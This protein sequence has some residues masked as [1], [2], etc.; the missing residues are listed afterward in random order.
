MAGWVRASSVAAR[1]WAASSMAKSQPFSRGRTSETAPELLEQ[2]GAIVVCAEDGRAALDLASPDFDAVLMDLQMP[3]MDGFEATRQWLANADLA[4]VPIIA[5]TANALHEDRDRVFAAGMR[6]FVAKPVD[7]AHLYAT[8]ARWVG[9]R[10][11]GSSRPAGPR[12][13]APPR[14]D[15]RPHGVGDDG[16]DPDLPGID[17]TPA[18]RHV[19]GNKSLLTR[20]LLRF[21]DSERDSVDR[22]ERAIASGDRVAAVRAAHTL[23]GLAATLGAGRVARSAAEVEAALTTGSRHDAPIERLRGALDVVLRGLARIGPAPELEASAPAPAELDPATREALERASSLLAT[24]DTEAIELLNALSGRV[25]HALQALF[26]EARACAAEFEFDDARA[27]V[28][29]MLK[30]PAP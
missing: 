18:L 22:I 6:D 20:L 5:M 17:I 23:K 2:A 13:A 14:S 24:Y 25:P 30:P 1:N 8:V 12:D 16:R 15:R 10:A 29:A 21:R 7:P 11:R 4:R 27:R 19:G 9:A 28:D 3:V 26:G